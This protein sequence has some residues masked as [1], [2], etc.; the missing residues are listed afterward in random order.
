MT[1]YMVVMNARHDIVDFTD[2]V[3]AR[4]AE[5]WQPLGGMAVHG[6]YLYQSMV[7]VV[8]RRAT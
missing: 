3:N 4:I 2:L 5:G 7:R 8:E 1:E 6:S